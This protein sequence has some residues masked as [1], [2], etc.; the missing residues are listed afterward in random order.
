MTLMPRDQYHL[1]LFVGIQ[2][3]Y[4]YLM[5]LNV[6]VPFE[7][8][9]KHSWMMRVFAG[10]EQIFMPSSKKIDAKNLMH[11]IHVGKRDIYV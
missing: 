2:W 11:K 8:I 10:L 3:K 1:K 7:I 9:Q 5:K 4:E 6:F